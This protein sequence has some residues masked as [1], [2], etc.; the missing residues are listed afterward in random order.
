M[1]TSLP[2]AI[3]EPDAARRCQLFQAFVRAQAGVSLIEVILV[4]VIVSV[5]MVSLA[6]VTIGGL[7]DNT[8]AELLATAAALATEKMEQVKAAKNSDGWPNLQAQN[9]PD[10]PNIQGYPGFSRTVSISTVANFKYV[11]VTVSHPAMTDLILETAFT[12]F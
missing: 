12:N 4:I 3:Y 8:N 6:K 11:T 1:V 2:S 5:A 10:E 7:T 9:F